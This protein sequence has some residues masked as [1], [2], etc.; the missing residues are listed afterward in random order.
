MIYINVPV[1]G[2]KDI[3]KLALDAI[4]PVLNSDLRLMVNDDCSPDGTREWLQEYLKDRPFVTLMLAETNGGCIVSR[5]QMLKACFA[6]KAVDAVIMMDNDVIVAS[7][8]ITNLIS[9]WRARPYWMVCGVEIGTEVKHFDDFVPFDNKDPLKLHRWCLA[10]LPRNTY[11]VIGPIDE[12][13]TRYGFDDSDYFDMIQCS[14]SERL[15]WSTCLAP[16]IHYKGS[17]H[18]WRTNPAVLTGILES[19]AYYIRKWEARGRDMSHMKKADSAFLSWVE[20]VEKGETI[21]SLVAEAIEVC[22]ALLIDDANARRE[23]LNEMRR[24]QD[25]S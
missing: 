17:H 8:S 5:N 23:H 6:D 20:R 15:V 21:E 25:G 14:T 16:Y 1:Y 11:E 12:G 24:R 10:L 2:Q 4:F 18:S 22:P 19:R 9:Y 13:F 7:Y 3:T